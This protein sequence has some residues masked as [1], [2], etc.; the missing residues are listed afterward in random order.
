MYIAASSQAAFLVARPTPRGRRVQQ[1]EEEVVLLRENN[2]LMVRK[3]RGLEPN[4]EPMF[5]D[6][7]RAEKSLDRQERLVIAG[8]GST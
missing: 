4:K 3:D 2:K 5:G 1:P 7:C 6:R 8:L